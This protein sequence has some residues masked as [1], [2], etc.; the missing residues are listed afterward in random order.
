MNK[1][2]KDLLREAEQLQ[3][4]LTQYKELYKRL[5]E[6]TDALVDQDISGSGF[7]IIDNFAEKSVVWKPCGV[8]RFELK[9]VGK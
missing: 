9:K 4:T 6:I 7:A 1:K 2:I 3:A 5:D 8:R